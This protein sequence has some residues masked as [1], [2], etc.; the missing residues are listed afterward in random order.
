M[1]VHAC[2]CLSVHPCSYD[3]IHNNFKLISLCS[4]RKSEDEWAFLGDKADMPSAY[5]VK[6]HKCSSLVAVL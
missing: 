4:T 5:W 1:F 3:N 2:V 6:V